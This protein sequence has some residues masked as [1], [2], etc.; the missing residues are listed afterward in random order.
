MRT[1]GATGARLERGGPVGKWT[2]GLGGLSVSL[3]LLEKGWGNKRRA[4]VNMLL[5]AWR[6][7]LAM[8]WKRVL[9][10]AVLDQARV[11]ERGAATALE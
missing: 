6:A 7:F 9:M 10:I 1:G 2:F 3:R 8:A 4:L 5:V 11:A